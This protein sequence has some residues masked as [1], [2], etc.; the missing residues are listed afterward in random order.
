MLPTIDLRAF[1]LTALNAIFI[2]MSVLL[3]STGL[4]AGQTQK[5]K[6]EGK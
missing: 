1:R 5:P 3:A 4:A 6:L 2:A